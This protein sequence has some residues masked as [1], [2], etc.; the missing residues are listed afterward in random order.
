MS[1]EQLEALIV[2]LTTIKNQKWFQ[3][4]EVEAIV[5]A[6]ISAQARASE[7]EDAARYRWLRNEAGVAQ[8][9]TPFCAIGEDDGDCM[10][11]C[12]ASLDFAIDEARSTGDAGRGETK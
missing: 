11:S 7:A 10:Y 2:G 6:A 12:G 5:A 9:S 3:R 8:G 4:A 1:A